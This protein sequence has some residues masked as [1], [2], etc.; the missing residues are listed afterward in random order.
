MRP[1]RIILL[2]VSVLV[3]ASLA[4]GPFGGSPT[5]EV[6][7]A[8]EVK[9]T[10]PPTR[11]PA[12]KVVA[13]PESSP[14]AKAVAT[15]ESTPDSVPEPAGATLEIT[16]ESNA[17]VW[18]VYVSPADSDEWGEDWLRDDII[19]VGET[20]TIAGIPEGTYDVKAEDEEGQVVEIAWEVV[21]EGDMTW[22]ISGLAAIEVINESD[23]TITYL[24]IS[25]VEST[26]WGEDL[27]GQDVIEP[28][29][30]YVLE[31][32]EQGS[33]D[34]KATDSNEDAIETTYDVAL[35]WDSYWTVTGI[36]PLADNAA[37]RFEDEFSDNRNNWGA[38]ETEFASHLAP[39]DGEYCIQIKTDNHTAWEWYEPFRTDEFIAEVGCYVD[40]LEDAS[41]GLGF[42]PDG[43]NLY[44]FEVTA[45][46]QQFALFLLENGEW[47]ESLIEWTESKNIDPNGSNYLSLERVDDIV[48]V[49]VNGVLVGEVWSD[50]FPEG[51][52]GIGGSTYD[53]PN[54]T[55]CLD[56]LRVWRLE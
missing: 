44:W 32:L 56:N 22:T 11:T 40:G 38:V 30:S 9:P 50:R 20:Y 31:G 42:G 8:D 21:L 49:F 37:L 13:T 4:C 26:S 43:D 34:M 29:A 39:A 27:L 28:G 15:P 12:P 48:S 5:A 36:A 54:A 6:T 45:W 46:D 7:P 33:Y 47:Q 1:A 55:I 16:N 25:P 24:Y 17:N 3:L 10:F 23:D 2:T 14:P 51:R 19:D 53:D 52:L 18:Y 41:C 35:Y